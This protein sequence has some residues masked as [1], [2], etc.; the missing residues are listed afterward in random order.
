VH[1]CDVGLPVE[2]QDSLLL[3]LAEQDLDGDGSRLGGIRVQ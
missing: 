1:E 3:S 2:Q